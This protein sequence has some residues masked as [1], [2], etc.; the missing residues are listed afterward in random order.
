MGEQDKPMLILQSFIMGKELRDQH[1]DNARIQCIKVYLLVNSPLY[2]CLLKDRCR[3]MGIKKIIARF[4][5]RIGI[6]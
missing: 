1:R 6:F 4:V 2:A 5:E 3:F